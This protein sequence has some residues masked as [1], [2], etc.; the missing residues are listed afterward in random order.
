MSKT[1]Y[2]KQQNNISGPFDRSELAELLKN[3]SL[4]PTDLVSQDQ[5]NYSAITSELASL[6]PELPPPPGQQ[7]EHIVILPE[8]GQTTK[9]AVKYSKKDIFISV[10]ALLGNGEENFH[11]LCTFS[12]TA[13]VSAG[14][15]CLLTGIFLTLS[16]C[17]LFG[18]LYNVAMT[19]L[20]TRS[21][22][23]VLLAGCLFWLNSLLAGA[24]APLPDKS[25]FSE[26]IFLAAMS[27]LLNIA[28]FTL[29]ANSMMFMFNS[30]LFEQI[31]FRNAAAVFAALLPGGF[32][33]LNT[34]LILRAYL[35]HNTRLN[36]A[37]ATFYAV[38]STWLTAVLF[39]IFMQKIYFTT[40]I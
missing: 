18:T 7:T 9:N 24:V 13:K 36:A 16:G 22:T 27:G 5:I 21:C 31:Y 2:I 17:L 23:F 40:Q 32:F 8:V 29:T 28:A 1:F 25:H 4:Q 12:T 20:I 39:V 6:F 37:P 35:L 26:N 30:I 14:I 34:V 11:K 10:I 38:L 3:G 19:S 33:M 15:L